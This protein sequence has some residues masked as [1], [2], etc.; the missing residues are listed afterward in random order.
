M[1][2]Q[3]LENGATFGAQRQ[4]INENFTE[5]YQSI[6]DNEI[7]LANKLNA[8]EEIPE[9][10]LPSFTATDIFA[11]FDN[12]DFKIEGGK[13]RSIATTT[14]SLAQTTITFGTSTTTQ[15]LVNWT[16]VTNA[17]SYVVERSLNS[18]MSSPTTIYTGALLNYTDTGLTASTTYYYRITAS[19]TN[20]ISSVSDIASKSTAASAGTGGLI[21]GKMISYGSN[22]TYDNVTGNFEGDGGAN[23][24]LAN[25]N[26]T[27]A[28]TL[29]ISELD[30]KYNAA[31]QGNFTNVGL[32]RSSGSAPYQTYDVGLL[33]LDS[34]NVSL[35][36]KSDSD[37]GSLLD[38][39]YTVTANANSRL[40]IKLTNGTTNKMVEFF[41]SV[42]NG[43][44]WVSR[45]EAAETA[46]PNSFAVYAHF[47]MASTSKVDNIK[48]TL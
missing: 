22:Q 26:D 2:K 5:V 38:S 19:A 41:S 36:T 30:I 3:K 16:A 43:A 17:T 6:E 48:Y 44:T 34:L 20:Y 4:K 15:N 31:W 46:I 13:I 42:D 37:G 23:T 14:P 47:F 28:S 21:A 27:T 40:K 39:G 24:T 7:A 12:R 1:A 35:R 11:L 10:I 9:G 8:D 45:G 29:A 33:I 25:T 18:N 32:S